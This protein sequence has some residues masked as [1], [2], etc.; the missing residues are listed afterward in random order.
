[1]G[2]DFIDP[3]FFSFQQL[4]VDDIHDMKCIRMCYT[5]SD[6]SKQV[7]PDTFPF[8]AD[9]LMKK[10]NEAVETP[11][12]GNKCVEF[13]IDRHNLSEKTLKA[14]VNQDPVSCARMFEDTLHQFGKIMLGCDFD[15]G[16]NTLRKTTPLQG[17]RSGAF[18][19]CLGAGLVSEVQSR[20]TLHAHIIAFGGISP[21]ILQRFANLEVVKVELIKTLESIFTTSLP[22]EVHVSQVMEDLQK[23][24]PANRGQ[25]TATL[26]RFQGA[27]QIRRFDESSVEKS[28]K[29]KQGIGL[30]RRNTIRKTCPDVMGRIL[31]SRRLKRDV[32]RNG[33]RTEFQSYSE[34]KIKQVAGRM[35]GR[36]GVHKHSKRCIAGKYGITRDSLAKPSSLNL[37]TKCIQ[38]NTDSADFVEHLPQTALGI[39]NA[40][41][42]M[43]PSVLPKIEKEEV[44]CRNASR[45]FKRYPLPK[46]DLRAIYWEL[47]RQPV[48]TVD[49]EAY[50]K[51]NGREILD[52]DA[53]YLTETL[54]NELKE[55]MAEEVGKIPGVVVDEIGALSEERR[56]KAYEHL[57]TRNAVIVEYSELVTALLGS[58]TAMYMIG[59]KQQANVVLFY[60]SNYVTKNVTSLAQSVIL[61]YKAKVSL[62]KYPSKAPDADE[63]DRQAKCYA[64]KFLNNYNLVG[65]IA[66]SQSACAL[67]GIKSQWTSITTTF[68]FWR[69][70]VSYSKRKYM[71][72]QD[73]AP[74]DSE[75]DSSEGTDDVETE[76][77]DEDS[78]GEAPSSAHDIFE[79][80]HVDEND[81]QLEGSTE[82]RRAEEV[83]RKVTFKHSKKRK[84][85]VDDDV[86]PM[87]A[88]DNAAIYNIGDTK[89]A[90]P[91]YAA[92][93]Y[94]GPELAFLNIYE[95]NAIMKWDRNTTLNRHAK[96]TT[97]EGPEEDGAEDAGQTSEE[98]PSRDKNRRFE[99]DM[100]HPLHKEYSQLILSKQRTPILAGIGIGPYPGPT[101]KKQNRTA[102]WKRAA[103]QWAYEILSIFSEWDLKTHV[104]TAGTT[105]KHF[106]KF[107]ESLQ[108]PESCHR[109]WAENA[110]TP[111]DADSE[112]FTDDDW[113]VFRNYGRLTLINNLIFDHR[114]TQADKLAYT[115]YRRRDNEVWS[116][117]VE[118][119]MQCWRGNPFG[120]SRDGELAGYTKKHKAAVQT[121]AQLRADNR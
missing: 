14:M 108:V 111:T 83:I 5:F 50:W 56:D 36:M 24:R 104:P 34:L 60:L 31:E 46:Q 55:L 72:D 119:E 16:I 81:F 54:M 93:I 117:L 98:I 26:L 62:K 29:R 38:L 32:N 42:V 77:S 95:Y 18:G 113:E 86:E 23:E 21:L 44:K 6:P 10:L 49:T 103:N 76:S 87:M 88:V 64:A 110:V 68:V 63:I 12:D 15:T 59:S 96:N 25:Y 8:N 20:G 112:S 28:D 89:V 115:L 69:N 9:D 106:C 107:M 85:K 116:N 35:I 27:E 99:F 121:I 82:Q 40:E 2:F 65:E 48:A 58:N 91:S 80:Y 78:Q 33:K 114:V 17:R 45:K 52:G 92:Y 84:P 79:R 75:A 105:W 90:V 70:A 101:P 73:I 51:Q 94:R 11:T 67:L 3:F 66:P 61:F 37:R 19:S 47:K 1:M 30:N 39:S 109:R 13:T 43:V 97:G 71:R 53:D 57:V 7:Y 4:T 102:K 74:G 120:L 100:N 41:C 22:M 118:K